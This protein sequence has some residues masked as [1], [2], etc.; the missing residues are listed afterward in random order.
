MN[1]LDG[2]SNDDL[3]YIIEDVPETRAEAGAQLLKQS[4]SNDD[5]CYIIKNVP[6]KRTE[7]WAQLLKQLNME[8][9]DEQKLIKQIADI[10][11]ADPDSLNMNGWH[12]G[13]SHCLAGWAT[14][15]NDSARQI[16][17]T[18]GPVIG[19]EIAGCAVLPNYA[20]LFYSSN[21]EVLEVLKEV[22]KS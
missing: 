16:E 9:V 15:L 19:P 10:V 13:T 2:K 20:H 6:E 14:I 18:E 12:C 7:A 22:S 11:L 17:L 3:C 4:P 21:E 5:L 1:T 8:P